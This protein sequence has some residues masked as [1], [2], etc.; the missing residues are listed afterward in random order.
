M[1]DNTV[2]LL[3]PSSSPSSNA[4]ILF[5]V[6]QDVKKADYRSLFTT[7]SSS[8]DVHAVRNGE[9]MNG[10]IEGMGKD[11]EDEEDEEVGEGRGE[12]EEEDEDEDEDEEEKK[13][14]TI[15]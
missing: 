8:K 10:G 9:G 3:P 12:E 5:Y 6:R 4:Y 1:N 7:L 13:K 15:V 14:C 11:E 2:S